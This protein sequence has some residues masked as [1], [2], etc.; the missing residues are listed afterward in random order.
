[1]ASATK[2]VASFLN[3]IFSPYEMDEQ[4]GRNQPVMQQGVSSG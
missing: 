1:M 4:H 3:F 2:P